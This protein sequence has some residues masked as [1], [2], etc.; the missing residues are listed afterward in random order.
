[1]KAKTLNQRLL[2]YL[3]LSVICIVSPYIATIIL[4]IF[5]GDR[6]SGMALGII[7]SVVLAHFIFAKIFLSVRPLI[8]YTL[9]LLTALI[10]VL[11]LKYILP[12][13]LIKTGFDMYGYWDL[14]VTHFITALITWELSYHLLLKSSNQTPS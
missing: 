9:P 1:M 6:E 12:L 2:Y 4:I 14:N 13:H 10:S 11:S 8:K 5:S 3:L 7:P